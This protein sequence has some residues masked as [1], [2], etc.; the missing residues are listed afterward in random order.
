MK[1]TIND[2]IQNHIAETPLLS[3]NTVVSSITETP[4]LSA[5]ATATSYC[6]NRSKNKLL[7]SSILS[8]LLSLFLVPQN[9]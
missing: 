4:P 8:F 3:A 1:S 6:S 7:F 2:S 5:N 9:K